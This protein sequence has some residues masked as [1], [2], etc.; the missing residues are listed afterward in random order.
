MQLNGEARTSL[1]CAFS[2]LA[3]PTNRF[4]PNRKSVV[5]RVFCDN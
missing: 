5:Q 4:A 3:S 2:I 1:N